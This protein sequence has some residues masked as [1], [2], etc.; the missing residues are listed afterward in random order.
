MVELLILAALLSGAAGG[1]T[2]EVQVEQMRSAR[3]FI[4]AC[5]SREPRHFPDCR[6]DPA[7]LKLSVRASDR[8][9]RFAGVAPGRYALTLF[10]DENANQRLDTALGIPREGFGFSRNPKVRFGAPKFS[11]VDMEVQRGFARHR[12]RMQY[13][14]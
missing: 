5:L 10:H 3:G 8:R 13:L 9:L 6:S 11:Q 1:A 4:H 2:I 12:V 7:A 14:L